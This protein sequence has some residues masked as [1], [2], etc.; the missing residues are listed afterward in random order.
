M[1]TI[2]RAHVAH[3]PRNPFVDDGGLEAYSDRAVGFADGGIV[4]C[5]SWGYV[6][7]AERVV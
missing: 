4:A 1:T 5:G 6:R 2:V 7:G 3:T